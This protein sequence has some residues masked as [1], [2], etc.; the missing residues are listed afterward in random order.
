MRKEF[1]GDIFGGNFQ[2]NIVE[3][4]IS[5]GFYLK[6]YQ[7]LNNWDWQY[8]RLWELTTLVME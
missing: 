4:K 6:L 7:V 2:L 8:E 3:C 5:K 1:N